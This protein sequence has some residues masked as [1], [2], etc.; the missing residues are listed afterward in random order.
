VRKFVVE[1]LPLL[2]LPAAQSS[3]SLSSPNEALNLL[4]IV[5]VTTTCSEAG[6]RY[7]QVKCHVSYVTCFSAR[8]SFLWLNGTELSEDETLAAQSCF[9]S[10]AD[11]LAIILVTIIWCSKAVHEGFGIIFYVYAS[12]AR[13][14]A[15]ATAFAEGSLIII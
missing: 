6:R 7:S 3:S 10:K 8:H 15:D 2:L 4:R 13:W 11:V 14:R 9:K 1:A 5:T 12:S